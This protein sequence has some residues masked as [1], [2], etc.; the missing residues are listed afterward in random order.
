MSL[1]LIIFL[2]LILISLTFFI[3]FIV[4]TARQ[5]GALHII[6]LSILFIESWVFLYFTAGVQYE[7]VRATRD[8]FRFRQEAEVAIERG[9]ALRFGSFKE[10]QDSLDAI[11]P[12]QGQ[13]ERLTIDRGRVWRQLTF[14]NIAGNNV[15]L[16]LQAPR[17]STVDGDFADPPAAAPQS[18]GGVSLPQN[19]VVYAFEEKET[20]EGYPLPVFYLGEYRVTRSDSVTGEI[21]LESTLP[22]LEMH[23]LRI[24]QGTASSW[25][26]YEMLPT[27]SHLAFAAPGAEPNDEAIFGRPDEEEIRSLLDGVSESIV[28]SYLKDG[29]KAT[30][31]DR[32]DTIWEQVNLLTEYTVDVDSDQS[33]DATVSGYFDQVG[34]SIDIRLKRNEPVSLAPGELRDNRIVVIESVA[35]DLV[36]RGIAER[37]QRI[38]VRPLNDY[39]GL[40]NRAH[41]K[42]FELAERIK[43]YDYQNQLIDQANQASQNMLA[44]RQRESQ[45]LN[46]D[47]NGYQ[48]EIQFLNSAVVQADAEVEK[49]KKDLSN[50]YRALHQHHRQQLVGS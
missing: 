47:L 23:R 39:L 31:D 1:G 43:Y 11:I 48:K 49:L 40:F 42:R 12:V 25:T 46:S 35:R 27:D 17:A 24:E 33:A 22:L 29:Q 41:S 3:V 19:L 5:W 37:V 8:A 18:T 10:V 16:V 30:D 4:K 14:A 13:L 50:L 32:S 7:R 38:F 34:R 44:I 26:L 28:S 20:E 45:R 2:L 9:R 6:L 21:H 15:E 36:S